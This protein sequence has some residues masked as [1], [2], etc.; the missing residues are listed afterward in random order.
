MGMIIPVS[1]IFNIEVIYSCSSNKGKKLK[2]EEKFSPRKLQGTAKGLEIYAFGVVKY[3]IRSESEGMIALWDQAYYF[4]GLPK[5]FRI[6]Y[7]QGISTPE[8]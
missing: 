2:L 1:V 5:G 8:G 3:S 4:L 7:S 6:I